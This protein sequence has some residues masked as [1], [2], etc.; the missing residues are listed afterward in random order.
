MSVNVVGVGE[1]S[2]TTKNNI[3]H[4]TNPQPNIYPIEN[5]KKLFFRN[6][7]FVGFG[8]KGNVIFKNIHRRKRE[9]EKMK[10]WIAKGIA[11]KVHAN[12][13]K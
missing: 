7:S 4:R 5:K 1:G 9:R 10:I 6:F 11:D 13:L 3:E 8:Y 12:C 2:F